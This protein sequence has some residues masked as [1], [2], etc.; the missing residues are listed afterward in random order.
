MPRINL[1]I[2]LPVFL[3][4]VGCKTLTFESGSGTN[5]Q[6]LSA[7]VQYTQY[8]ANCRGQCLEDQFQDIKTEIANRP[9]ALGYLRLALILAEKGPDHSYLKRSA[10][11]LKAMA[12]DKRMSE[13][14][15]AFAESHYHRVNAMRVLAK[16]KESL[17]KKLKQEA[18][19]KGLLEDKLHALSKLEQ[20]LEQAESQPLKE[21]R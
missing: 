16:S 10:L 12:A 6:N 19:S 2:L 7:W 8:L 1:S 4:A 3:L 14:M 13:D 17:E 20:S 11:L 21:Q 15:K 18:K 9:S 5:S